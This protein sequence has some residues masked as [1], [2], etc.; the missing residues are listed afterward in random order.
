MTMNQAAGHFIHDPLRIRDAAVIK[1]L[2]HTIRLR[3]LSAL[4]GRNC[5]V[6]ELWELLDIEQ[7]VVSQHLALLKNQGI[8]AGQRRGVRIYYEIMHPL[9]QSIISLIMQH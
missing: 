7:A 2:G 4:N 5:T 3:I 9:A 6:K 1:L 8:V